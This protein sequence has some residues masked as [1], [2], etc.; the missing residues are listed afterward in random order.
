MPFLN[1]IRDRLTVREEIDSRDAVAEA[2][3]PPTA[4][5][6]ESAVTAT[7][8]DP[9]KCPSFDEEPWKSRAERLRPASLDV[10]SLADVAA[11]PPMPPLKLG[12][13][14]VRL[15]LRYL[16]SIPEECWIDEENE[17]D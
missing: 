7:Q 9:I 15:V 3:P 11:I 8:S 14:Y 17:Q 2:A 13:P 1:W 16:D 12:H 6:P 4:T 5:S 10:Y